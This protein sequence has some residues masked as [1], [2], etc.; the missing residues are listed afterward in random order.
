MASVKSFAVFPLFWRENSVFCAAPSG[1]TD[2]LTMSFVIIPPSFAAFRHGWLAKKSTENKSNKCNLS[3]FL[4]AALRRAF[5]IKIPSVF[6]PFPLLFPRSY[7][8]MK[9]TYMRVAPFVLVSA[10]FAHSALF[11]FA[12][13]C[14][15]HVLL[16][17]LCLPCGF[18][19]RLPFLRFSL[20]LLRPLA[21]PRGIFST[22]RHIRRASCPD[23][24][25]RV[26]AAFAACVCD[27]A[28]ERI[29]RERASYI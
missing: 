5:F 7:V 29:L 8:I 21:L 13:M 22:R 4:T 25:L 2:I 6:L 11:V 26:P 17:C 27:A 3:S 12:R 10:G 18:H 15:P 19:F 9:T 24:A 14:F 23:S 1:V 16:L 28:R 20:A